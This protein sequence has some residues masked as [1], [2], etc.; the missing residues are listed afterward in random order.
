MW[1][2]KPRNAGNTTD[3]SGDNYAIGG[4]EEAQDVVESTHDSFDSSQHKNWLGN[5]AGLGIYAHGRIH[6]DLN[7]LIY[8]GDLIHK[9]G[10]GATDDLLKMEEQTT[11]NQGEPLSANSRLGKLRAMAVLPTMNTAN[12]EGD[13][14][15]YYDSGVVSFNTFESPRATLVDGDGNSIAKGWDSKRLISHLLNTVSA[16]GRYA[17][18]VL[19]R[20]HLFRSEFGLHL[21]KTA[22][23]EG[24]FN[25]EQIN[26]LSMDVDPLLAADSAYLLPGAATGHWVHGDRM[27]AT[28]GLRADSAITAT[29]YGR[30]FVSW[31][32]ATTFTED[33][34]PVPVWEGLWTIDNGMAGVHWFGDIGVR[35]LPGSF[36]FV[37]SDR[38]GEIY[39][40]SINRDASADSRD[41]EILPIEWSFE[42][43]RFAMDGLSSNKSVRGGRIEGVFSGE[44]SNVR[45][46]IRTDR[47]DWALWKEFI[48]CEGISGAD[49][50]LTSESLGL[51]NA[52]ARTGTWFQV[53]VEGRG[54][55]EIR[56]ID[57]DYSPETGKSERS[58]CSVATSAEVDPFIINS[59]PAESRWNS[60]SS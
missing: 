21:L 10:H 19:P 9:R 58:Q 15:A 29:S 3:M 45:V 51:P 40:A 35:S 39:F 56:V 31:N 26:R 34:T 1:T 6:Q 55:A 42:T 37:A 11:L 18:A 8:V 38:D 59:F 52:S 4:G 48:P 57:L 28:T 44:S 24:S 41:G 53:R 50:V 33:R 17:V 20:D 23:G 5:S 14:I 36:G 60:E 22:L 7:R 32:Q 49:K 47:S 46:L 30:G 27:F 25:T 43:G 2:P 16:V 12:G 13:L 54:A